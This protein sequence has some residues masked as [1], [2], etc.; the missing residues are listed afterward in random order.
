MGPFANL[1]ERVEYIGREIVYKFTTEQDF[2]RGVEALLEN[3]FLMMF[4]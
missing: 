2:S 4:F 1:I 3:S